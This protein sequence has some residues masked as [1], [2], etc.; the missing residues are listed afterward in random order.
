MGILAIVLG[1]FP[2]Q[3]CFDHLQADRQTPFASAASASFGVIWSLHCLNY[4]Q[5]GISVSVFLAGADT[6]VGS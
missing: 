3:F 6:W 1:T 4:A 2:E 5:G